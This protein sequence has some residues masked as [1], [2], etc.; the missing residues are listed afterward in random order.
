MVV[1]SFDNMAVR[2]VLS[3]GRIYD[4]TDGILH[5][6]VFMVRPEKFLAEKSV[7]SYY[8]VSSLFHYI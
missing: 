5:H 4:G 8:P 2:N 3:F 7:Y 6:F 1:E